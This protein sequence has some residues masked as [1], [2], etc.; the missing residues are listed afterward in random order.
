MYSKRVARDILDYGE[1]I[2]FEG[3]RTTDLRGI[4]YSSIGIIL[5]G[6]IYEALKNYREYLNVSIAIQNTG[7][8]SRVQSIFSVVHFVQTLLQ[9]IQ[10]TISYF[11]M[12]IFMTYNVYLCIAVTIGIMLGYFLFSW[13]NTR[14]DINQ[15]CS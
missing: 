14:C 5:L 7:Q 12:F 3:W 8:K 2:L 9:G 4:I 11:L 1:T 10:I 13:N 15:C 6:I